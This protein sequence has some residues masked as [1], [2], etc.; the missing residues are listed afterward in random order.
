[1]DPTRIELV[2]GALQVLLAPLVH[3]G[4]YLLQIRWESL[5][6][7]ASALSVRVVVS[8]VWRKTE[9]TLPNQYLRTDPFVFET[10]LVL[11]EL[12]FHNFCRL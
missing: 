12:I 6:L 7:A 5:P 3:A 1:M 9:V 10:S 11:D 4:P 8:V 2:A